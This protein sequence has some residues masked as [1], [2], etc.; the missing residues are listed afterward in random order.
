MSRVIGLDVRADRVR[1]AVVRGGL[2]T[3]Q[4]E[5][6]KSAARAVDQPVE[7]VVRALMAEL[8]SGG[9]RVDG[10]VGCIPARQAFVQYARFP[11]SAQK[12]I[13]QL[14][15]FELEADLP[16]DIDDLVF[17]H[18]PLP[19]MTDGSDE[20]VNQLAACARID[21]VQDLITQV[22]EATGHEPERVGVSA[23]ELGLLVELW[24]G[25]G[26]GEP[27]LIVEVGRKSSETCV[28]SK[29]IVRGARSLPFG[30]EAFPR[31]ATAFVAQLRQTIVAHETRAFEVPVGSM[32]LVG[33]GAMVSGLREFLESSLA[34][35]VFVLEAQTARQGAFETVPAEDAALVH[36][37]ACAIGLALHGVKGRGFDLRQGPLAF[38]RGY[39]FIKERAPLLSAL[40][41]TILFSFIFSTWAEGRALERDHEVLVKTLELVTQDAFGEASPDPDEARALMDRFL[42]VNPEDP[43]PYMDGFGA[44]VTLA[45]V[46]PMDLTHDVE[47]FEFT[48]GKL[49]IRGLVETTEDAQDVAKFLEEDDCLSEVKITKITQ[50]VNSERARYMLEADVR[51]PLDKQPEEA[52]K[53]TTA[54][55]QQ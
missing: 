34:L 49:K 47:Q 33:E 50:V 42:K 26:A 13:D 23:L 37:F 10:V 20:V 24:P 9:G 19:P 2:R 55:A 32:Y 16:L 12:R 54:G 8:T 14:L 6:L 11:K 27:A 41:V 40:A 31:D 45:K 5:A 3:A 46:L 51:C 43:M 1:I 38:S 48:K 39:G 21:Q 4:V 53:K 17:T 18:Q 29:G 36:E 52:K 44:A 30:T 25:L 7:E 22:R 35:P 15:P 28:V